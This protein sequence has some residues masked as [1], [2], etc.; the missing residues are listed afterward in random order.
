[1]ES[2]SQDGRFAVLGGRLNHARG[3]TNVLARFLG[4]PAR[5]TL[6]QIRTG[7]GAMEGSALLSRDAPNKDHRTRYTRRLFV[8]FLSLVCH[9][10]VSP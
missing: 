5:S 3:F 6:R 9:R 2:L 8:T 10:A 4:Q 1:M 7:I